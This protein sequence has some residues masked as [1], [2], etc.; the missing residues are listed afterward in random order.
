M[1]NAASATGATPEGADSRTSRRYGLAVLALT[2]VALLLRLWTLDF[3]LPFAQEP[4]PHILG[5]V[6]LL[7]KDTVGERDVFYS[8]IYPHLLARTAMLFGDVT[9]APAGLESM[10]LEEHLAAASRLHIRVRE[11]IAWFSVLIVPATWWLARSFFERKWALF[12]AALAATS[13]LSLQFGQMARP[14]AAVA[15]LIVLSVAACVRLRRRGDTASFW[16][17][18]AAAALAMATLQNATVALLALIAAYLLREGAVGWRRL[19][20]ARLLIPFALLAAALWFFWPY[21]FVETPA[22]AAATSGS[23]DSQ[24]DVGL[25]VRLSLAL[26]LVA[27][28]VLGVAFEALHEPRRPRVRLAAWAA[29]AV[30]ATIVWSVHTRTLHVGWQTIELSQFAGQGFPTLFTTFWYYEPLALALAMCG[31]IA[32]ITHKSEPAPGGIARRKDLLVVLSFALVYALVIGLYE[33]NQQRFALP[34]VPFVACLAACGLR[35]LWTNTSR[36][37]FGRA[38]AAFVTVVAL[39]IPALACIGYSR[40][41]T[42]PQ[43]LEQLAQWLRANIDPAW[44][45]VALHLNYDVPLARRHDDLFKQDG[46]ARKVNLSP[47]QGYQERWLDAVWKGERFDIASLFEERNQ[48]VLAS[49]V[50]NPDEYVRSLDVDVV[51]IPGGEGP[52]ANPVTKAVR[53]SL[54]RT[55]ELVL[56]L[57]REARPPTSG[58]E[59]LDTPHFTAF[60]LSA[61]SFGPQLEVY[62]LPRAKTEQR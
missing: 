17:A 50:A 32:W 36:N 33:R 23:P 7:S 1:A 51:V 14:H 2:L 34:L 45:R 27:L 6:E 46:G 44:Q 38:F 59:G 53:D 35:A 25:V 62:R 11:I 16:I 57:P 39:A 55:A 10:S 42:R 43:T 21:L 26:I 8:S 13:T 49:I 58:L 40:M 60:V 5:Q 52:S 30:G 61:E 37:T 22:D 12:A 48:K 29:A 41:R 15:P 20:D 47:W 18:G 24:P 28:G 54:A 4:D 3:A 9:R 56:T 31:V 19:F